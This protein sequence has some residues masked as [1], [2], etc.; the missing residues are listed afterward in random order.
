MNSLKAKV[1]RAMIRKGVPFRT[2][3]KM[4][5]DVTFPKNPKLLGT[6]TKIEK[7]EKNGVLTAVLYLSPANRSVPYGGTDLCPFATAGCRA[8]CLGHTAGRMPMH[9]SQNAQVWKTL[10]FRYLRQEFFEMLVA[11]IER[12]KQKAFRKGYRAAV[13]LNGT[14]DIDWYGIMPML[15]AIHND[16][17]F[18]DYTKSYGRALKYRFTDYHI[19][20][21]RTEQ[22]D[23]DTVQNLLRKGVNVAVVFRDRLPR[24]YLGFPVVD[25]DKTDYRPDDPSGVVVGLTVKGNVSDDTG[26]FV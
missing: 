25:G 12:H 23:N 6:S 24:T 5:R 1:A 26:F 3:G 10:F 22:D 17:Q 8:V 20:Y 15:F 2:V 7:G 18:Y 11:D 13:R 19:T 4:L 16:V 9:S 14:S 21:S